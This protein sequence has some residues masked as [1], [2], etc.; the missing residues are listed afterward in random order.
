[1]LLGTRVRRV[2]VPTGVAC[3]PSDFIPSPPKAVAERAFAVTRLTEMPAGGH[4]AA[5]EEP[6]A[7]SDEV[8]AFFG[9][10]LLGN[11]PYACPRLRPC[12]TAHEP[13]GTDPA[14][15]PGSRL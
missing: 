9:N 3:F 7:F 13:A 11:I 8:R 4:F 12:R 14:L 10:R 2:K 5:R 6:I 1:M 15:L